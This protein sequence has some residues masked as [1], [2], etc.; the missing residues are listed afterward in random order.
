MKRIDLLSALSPLALFA[1]LTGGQQAHAS[2][3]PSVSTWLQEQASAGHVASATYAEIDGEDI[4]SGGVGHRDG[5]SGEAP[6][7]DT[8]YQFGSITKVF[9]HLLLAERVAAGTLTYNSSIGELLP[10]AVVPKNP[11]VAKI[12][13]QSLATHHSGLPRLPANLDLSNTVDPYAGYDQA[14][15]YAGITTTRDQ[16]PLGSFYAYSNFGVGLLGHL[17]GRQSGEGYHEAVISE[18]VEPL[19]LTRTAFERG[20]NSARAMQGGEPVQPWGFDDALTGAGGLSGSVNDL[21]RLAQAFMGKHEHSLKHALADDLTVVA[22]AGQFDVTRVWHV[23]RAGDAP[24]FWHNGGTAGFHTFVGFRP[25]SGR[26]VAILISG[27]ADPTAIGLRS[28]GMTPTRTEPEPADAS[29][30]GQYPLSP[31]FGVGVYIE[32]GTLFAQATG[33]PAFALHAL[34]ED[35]YALAEVD[36]SLHFL[37]DGDQVTGLELAQGGAL[38]KAP[39]ASDV[40][41]VK[42]R[43]ELT[44][45]PEALAEFTGQFEFAPGVLLTVRQQGDGIQ[46][47]L[48]GQSFV[49]VYSRGDDRFFYKV[50]EAELEFERDASGAIV[51]VVLH[52]SGIEQRARRVDGK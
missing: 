25:D 26:G 36:A 48:T 46:A 45:A 7:A 27:D 11:A 3:V 51:A 33:Q 1:A 28:L 40:A 4:R 24:I 31:Q 38:N 39:R 37:R 10:A 42:K 30:V 12:T 22:S 35:W 52:Q 13:L 14:A 32:N 18:V 23:A 41:D 29:V 43:K 17:L 5:V 44:L 50:V 20:G 16:Q 9:T 8:Q 15:L 34:G 21:A 49:P 47:Q 2:E 19:G 6:N